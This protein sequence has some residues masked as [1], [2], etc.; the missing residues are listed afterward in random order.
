MKWACLIALVALTGCRADSGPD[1]YISQERFR[2]DASPPPIDAD[3]EDGEERLS[4]GAFYEGPAVE[5]VVIDELQTHFYI[6]EGTFTVA[7]DDADKVEG[8]QSDRLQTVGGPWWGGGVHWDTP[9]DL[10]GWDTLHVSLKSGDASM[11]GFKIAM[12]APNEAQ[13]QI[14]LAEYGWAADGAWHRLEIPL[15]DVADAGMDL[16]QVAA[17]LVFVGGAGEAGD[18]VSVDDVYFSR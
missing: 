1:D 5:V 17:P 8:A 9:R 10:S 7:I 14:D 4:I 16:T 3:I 13:T 2:L 11:A 15:A 6:Y 12:N 18:A